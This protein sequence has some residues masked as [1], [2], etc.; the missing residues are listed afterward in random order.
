MEYNVNEE[1]KYPDMKNAS[2][3]EIAR[4]GVFVLNERNA[5]DIKLLHVEEK[6]VLTDYFVVCSGNSTTQVK[7]LADEIEFR[8]SQSGIERINTELDTDYQWIALDYGC[9][10]IHV[11]LYS[12][13][14]FY[15]LD[16]LWG[17]AEET[18]ISDLLFDK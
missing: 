17:T 18:D 5:R 11:F 6:T 8:F 10:M 7:A 16:K 3:L 14:D 9:V 2:A 12:A 1:N 13:R 15:K 4:Y